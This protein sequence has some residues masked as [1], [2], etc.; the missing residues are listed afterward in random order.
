[1]ASTDR[2]PFWLLAAGVLIGFSLLFVGGP[3]YTSNRLL[4][5]LWGLGH[6]PFM[7]VFGLA[8]VR[9]LYRTKLN[10]QWALPAIYGSVVITF[11]I[12][13]EHLQGY[14]GRTESLSDLLADLFGALLALLLVSR[15]QIDLGVKGRNI[16]SGLTI[17]I[18]IMV[19]IPPATIVYDDIVA[20]NQFPM[21]AGFEHRT[22]LNRWK[23]SSG[24][25]RSTERTTEGQYSLKFLLSTKKYSAISLKDF[26]SNWQDYRLL[27]FDIWS[28]RSSLP[29]NVRIHD[30]EHARGTGAYSDRFNRSYRLTNGWNRILIDLSEVQYS[31]RERE[32]NLKEIFRLLLFSHNLETS[33]TLY[34]DQLILMH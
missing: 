26:P 29:I 19:I 30:K 5:V 16:F 28:P 9:L 15:F 6:I 17:V 22:E 34:L 21:I 23:G 25:W 3:D 18:G 11:A 33:E 10:P 4:K 32:L 7:F 8:L 2:I 12:A 31:P 1:M 13:T 24:I 20:R 27:R 14:V